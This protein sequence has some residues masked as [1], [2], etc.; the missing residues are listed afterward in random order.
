MDHGHA[1]GLKWPPHVCVPCENHL[2]S[3]T[4]FHP[5]APLREPTSGPLENM[6]LRARCRLPR[7]APASAQQYVSPCV[8]PLRTRRQRAPDSTLVARTMRTASSRVITCSVNC[9]EKESVTILVAA[10]SGH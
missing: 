7:K 3:R 10:G 8:A 4:S 2:G 1:G 5:Q 6:L 9:A